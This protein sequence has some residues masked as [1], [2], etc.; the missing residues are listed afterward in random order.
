MYR[1]L[2]VA[3]TRCL[4]D[5]GLGRHPPFRCRPLPLHMQTLSPPVNRLTFVK[6]LSFLA[7]GK[8]HW[9]YMIKPNSPNKINA[10]RPVYVPIICCIL[11]A[12]LQTVLCVSV[13]HYQILDSCALAKFPA[14]KFPSLGST[15]CEI[16]SFRI[17]KSLNQQFCDIYSYIFCEAP[18]ISTGLH[19]LL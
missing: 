6:R 10:N 16:F 15:K 5:E 11:C 13:T 7:V 4:Y 12:F 9:F 1:P 17:K 2:Q 14:T 19:T 8:K 18:I 3:T